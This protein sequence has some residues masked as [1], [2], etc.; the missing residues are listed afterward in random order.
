M[1]RLLY[2]NSGLRFKDRGVRLQS[3][4]WLIFS[5]TFVT[6]YTGRFV[7]QDIC[8]GSKDLLGVSLSN[9]VNKAVCHVTTKT[10]NFGSWVRQAVLIWMHKWSLA[11]LAPSTSDSPHSLHT[12]RSA[13][14]STWK[15]YSIWP[16]DQTILLLSINCFGGDGSPQSLTMRP[17]LLRTCRGQKLV[18]IVRQEKKSM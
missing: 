17:P 14:H 7:W 11:G 18:F 6:R 13:C 8:W 15:K 4:E 12:V 10:N 2:F 3:A 9:Y 5:L 16:T 1:S